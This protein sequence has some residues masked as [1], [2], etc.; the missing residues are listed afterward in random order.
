[1]RGRHASI[2][3]GVKVRLTAAR[4]RVWSGRSR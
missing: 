1:M 4:S 2:A 3:L